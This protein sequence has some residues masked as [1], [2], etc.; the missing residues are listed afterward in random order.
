MTTFQKLRLY[1]ATLACGS[2]LAYLTGELGLIHAWLGYGIAAVIMLRVVWGVVGPRQVG[3]AHLVPTIS[4]ISAIRWINH[5]AISKILLTGIIANILL[6]TATGIAM[7]DF[8]SLSRQPQ[9]AATVSLAGDRIATQAEIKIDKARG[10]GIVA[11]ARADDRKGERHEGKSEGWL[12]ELHEATA[13]LL[14]IFVGLHVSY[15]ILFK[16]KLAFY[17]LFKD[18]PPRQRIGGSN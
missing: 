13:N 10:R 7:D 8:A 2:V 5:P 16:R 6:V 9:Q 12:G 15:V 17:M 3:M 14:F 1:H 4:E 11:S 18:T